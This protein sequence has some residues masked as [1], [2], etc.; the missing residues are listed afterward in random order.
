MFFRAF[1]VFKNLSGAA[2]IKK[3]G[4]DFPGYNAG[5]SQ[6]FRSHEK[7]MCHGETHNKSNSCQLFDD[8][9]DGRSFG[10]AFAVKV[11]IDHRGN[12]AKRKQDAQNL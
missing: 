12:A 10:V 8:L 1:F 9:G 5:D 6:F 4:N 7:N 3:T 11:T 2:D